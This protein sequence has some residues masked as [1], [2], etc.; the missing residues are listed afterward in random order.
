[1]EN[2]NQNKKEEK[3]KKE[4]QK[5]NQEKKEVKIPNKFKDIVSQVEKMSVLELSEL[6]KIL[7][8]KFGVCATGPMM[9]AGAGSTG[10]AGSPEEKEEKTSFNVVLSNAGSQKIQVIKALRELLNVGLK[11][12]KEMTDNVPKTVKEGVSKEEAEEVK[13][14]LEEAGATVEIK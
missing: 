1:M 4:S 2:K 5:E 3:N 10:A 11:E 13:K 7:E 12:A 8:D 6:V 9:V 14:K